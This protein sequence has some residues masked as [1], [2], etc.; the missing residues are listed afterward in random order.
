MDAV[1]YWR[2]IAQTNEE[3]V[4][5]ACQAVGAAGY[6]LGPYCRLSEAERLATLRELFADLRQALGLTAETTLDPTHPDPRS[7]TPPVQGDEF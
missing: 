1:Q 6:Y 3:R 7:D 4:N 5:A 2:T